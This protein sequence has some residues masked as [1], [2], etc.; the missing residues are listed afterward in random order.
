VIPLVLGIEAC[1][2]SPENNM[3]PP[4]GGTTVSRVASAG[5]PF[6]GA[7]CTRASLPPLKSL[8]FPRQVLAT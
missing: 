6:T 8:M 3:I 4:S 2:W 7:G 5:I 1:S